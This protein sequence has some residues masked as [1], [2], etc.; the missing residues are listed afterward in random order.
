MTLRKV[1]GTY[2]V[3]VSG[4]GGKRR[5]ITTGCT[6]RGAALKVVAESGVSYLESAAKAGRLTREAIGHITTGR[7]LTMAKVLE[8]FAEWMATCARSP[9]TIDN[10]LTTL[11]CWLAEMRLSDKHPGAITALDISLWVN[12]RG[13]SKFSTRKVLLSCI[14]TLFTFMATNGWVLVD[15]SKLVAVDLS[16][17]THAQKESTERVP[18]TDDEVFKLLEYLENNSEWFWYFA[19][20]CASETGLRLGDICQLDWANFAPLNFGSQPIVLPKLVIWTD[21]TN[22]RVE[23][24]VSH[25]LY[26]AA[27]KV[28][29]VSTY[30]FPEQRAI[31]LD[32]KKRSLLSVQFKRIC[33]GL[34]IKGKSFHNLRHGY[35]TKQS[36]DLNESK[37]D[38]AKRLANSLSKKEL[39]TMLGHSNTK[40]QEV[41]VH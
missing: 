19:V 16:K 4:K 13:N 10:N 7:R 6:E 22:A 41:Y 26:D 14:R 36:K 12:A 32:V 9:K 30:L 5:L 20:L 18:F 37:L 23:H 24:P 40:T 2:H 8:P 15:V 11:R 3:S 29:A 33:D 25:Q 35:A 38:M 39:A 17:L 21:K 28:P 27:S 31:A 1:R 34:G